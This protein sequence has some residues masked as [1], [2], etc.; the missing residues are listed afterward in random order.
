MA[1]YNPTRPQYDV[2]SE[3][4]TFQDAVDHL[5]DCEGMDNTELNVRHA[6][7]AILRAYRDLP[8]NHSWNYYKRRF[9]FATAAQQTSSTITYD[10]TGG[11]SERLLTLA[12]GSWPTDASLYR[13]IISDRHYPIQTYESTSTLTLNQNDNPGADVAAGTSYTLY[14]SSYVLPVGTR[15]MHR[16]FDVTGDY[17]LYKFSSEEQNATTSYYDSPSTPIGYDIR[18]T[19]DY[20]NQMSVVFGPPPSS[21]KNYEAILEMSPR[22]LLTQEINSATASTVGT[23]LTM[24]T[25][26]LDTV[27]HVGSVIRFNTSGTTAPTSIIGGPGGLQAYDEQRIITAVSSGTGATLDSALPSNISTK[28]ATIS[29]PLDLEYHSMLTYFLRIAEAELAR[30]VKAQDVQERD[31]TAAMTLQMAAAA[32]LKDVTSSHT[33]VSPIPFHLRDWSAVPDETISSS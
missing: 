19:G 33:G 32:D 11:A 15:R 21:S 26:V 27:R 14:R 6:K 22:P 5:L 8:N 13:I 30:L 7:R 9:G 10:H 1:D 29:D 23:A 4:W 2:H 24:G 25:S 18:S 3:L 20:F 31:V 16:L 12:S 17:P 28:G